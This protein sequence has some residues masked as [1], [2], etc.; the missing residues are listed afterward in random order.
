MSDTP[1]R[2]YIQGYKVAGWSS[3]WTTEPQ[4]DKPDSPYSREA[5]YVLAPTADEWR[6]QR[7]MLAEACRRALDAE[8]RYRDKAFPGSILRDALMALDAEGAAAIAGCEG[9]KE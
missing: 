9:V 8:S 7:D 6:R 3:L 4:L 2:I 5:S 1:E